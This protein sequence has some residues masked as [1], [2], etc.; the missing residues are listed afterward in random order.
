MSK[1][2]SKT[3]LL[4][5]SVVIVATAVYLAHTNTKHFETTVINQTQQHLLTIAETEA[6][7][8]EQIISHIQEE[9]ERLAENSQLHRNIT[10]NTIVKS[11]SDKN[12]Y[13]PE[14]NAFDCL[15]ERATALYRINANGIVQNRIPFKAER[16]STNYSHKPGVKY[17]IENHKPY[18]SEV[19]RTSSKD[20]CISIC[21]PVFKGK[22]FI[23][24]VRAII[25]LDTI[26]NMVSHIKVGH[27]GYAWIIDE[28]IVMIAHPK[29]GHL[30]KNVLELR[31]KTFPKHDWADVKR[32]LARMAGGQQGVA[33]HHSAWWHD[34]KLQIVKKISAF[35]PINI[36][37]E[38][39]S[40]GV[41]MSYDEVAGPV[42]AHARNFSFAVIVLILTVIG[43]AFEYRKLEKKQVE[44]DA[45][46]K[47]A[48][49]LKAANQ[50]LQTEITERRQA[51]DALENLNEE[52]ESIVDKLTASNLELQN[53]S[54]ITA[55]DLKEPLRAIGTLAN[56][57][58]VDYNDKFDEKGKEKLDLLV[59]RT[60][61]MSALIDGILQYSIIGRAANNR[62]YVNLN[63]VV[64]TI[65]T[66]IDTPKNIKITIK[67]N[68]PTIK[69][70]RLYMAQVFN[71]L[72]GNAIK[73][74][75]K[76]QGQIE[77]NCVEEEDF[78]K[79]TVTDNG[80][81]ID[82]KYFKKIFQIFQTLSTRDELESTGVGLAVVRKIIELHKGRVWIE[83][84]LGKGSIFCFELPKHEDDII[85]EEVKIEADAAV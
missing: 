48:N 58:S 14:A 54:Y 15:G 77:I 69:C 61:R 25:S 46:T 5:I 6:R 44:L 53:L 84:E 27:K 74:M 76:P 80:P 55:H 60:K 19:F 3:I 21:Q 7:N 57:L 49:K 72:L 20:K 70:E 68:L 75:D 33:I 10:S 17:V 63:S 50:Q 13:S 79:F 66:E 4:L 59:G 18:I 51:E 29:P 52:L 8:I 65:V 62:G 37:N 42:K 64:K 82:G 28:N 47:S 73:Y 85:E 12:K 22:K 71:H 78:W 30:G 35:A 9:L 39:W 1:T 2:G 34:A 40:I 43:V 31:K 32:L 16:V 81:G 26:Q 83:S 56:W 45:Q 23:G 24:V 41:C 38:M 11:N 67:E 36:G